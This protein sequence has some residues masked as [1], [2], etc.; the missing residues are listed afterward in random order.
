MPNDNIKIKREVWRSM[1]YI[2]R[3]MKCPPDTAKVLV[4]VFGEKIMNDIE[5]INPEDLKEDEQT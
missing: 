2:P 1:H 4:D 5:I 3:K